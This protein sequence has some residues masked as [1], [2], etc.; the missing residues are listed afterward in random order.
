MSTLPANYE[1]SSA[2]EKLALLW[3]RIMS[4]RYAELPP[5]ASGVE[6]AVASVP[7]AESVPW[8][9]LVLDTPFVAS[10]YGDG[11]LFFQHQFR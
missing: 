7:E 4:E 3:E 2:D 9:E 10:R 1:G 5:D 8:A 6:S 11:V